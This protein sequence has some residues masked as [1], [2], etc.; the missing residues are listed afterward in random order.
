MAK[1]AAQVSSATYG[2]ITTGARLVNQLHDATV[3]QQ[4][5]RVGASKA[6]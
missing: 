6:Q 3:P 4:S 5:I 1:Y 2:A